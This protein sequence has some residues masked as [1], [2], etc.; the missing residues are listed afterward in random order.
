MKHDDCDNDICDSTQFLP[1]QKN[2]IIDLQGSLERYCNSLPVL[3]FN[4]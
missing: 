2:Q 4:S 1:I 3:G